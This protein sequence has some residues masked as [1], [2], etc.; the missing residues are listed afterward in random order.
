LNSYVSLD[1]PATY[2]SDKEEGPT[3]EVV[4]GYADWDP[5]EIFI[6]LESF[7][8]LSEA[9]HSALSALEQDVLRLYVGGRSYQEI[10]DALGRHVKVIDN[11]LHRIKRKLKASVQ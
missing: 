4:L 2:L 7:E 8:Q 3:K 9:I 11:A 10:A 6:S 5:A 1:Q